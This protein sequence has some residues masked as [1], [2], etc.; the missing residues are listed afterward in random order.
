VLTFTDSISSNGVR[1]RFSAKP[2]ER[3][4]GILKAN[5]FRWSP[6]AGHWWR[7]RISDAAEFLWA[8]DRALN[9]GRPDGACWVCK[10]PNGFFRSEG[11]ATPVR[12]YA[13]QAAA[14]AKR[15]APD[16]SDPARED[17]KVNLQCERI[18]SAQDECACDLCRKSL[19]AGDDAF[20][21]LKRGNA[22]CSRA[23]AEEDALDCGYGPV[24]LA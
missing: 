22:Y 2:D 15:S 17:R 23:C 19:A 24:C 4:R 7:R 21:D 16:R 6:N 9:P 8:L 1:I 12:C 11:P 5:G 14:L 13:C 10:S 18:K 20:V 3:I